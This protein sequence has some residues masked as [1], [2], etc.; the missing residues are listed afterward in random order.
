MEY[1]N[2]SYGSVTYGG[3]LL[4]P[5]NP[6]EQMPISVRD[7]YNQVCDCILESG[8]LTGETLSSD[9]FL[10]FLND[11]LRDVL[12]ASNC[13]IK[14]QNLVTSNGTRVYT[15]PYYV[16]QTVGMLCDDASLFRSSG[17]YWDNSDYYWQAK[18]SSTPG[19]WRD[20]ELPED[21]VEVRPAPSWYGYTVDYGSG[22][23]GTF[24]A[25]SNINTFQVAYAASMYG[26]MQDGVAGDVYT[27]FTAPMYGTIATIYDS[28]L[29]LTEFDTYTQESE[30]SS[31]DAFIQDLPVSFG[32]YVKFGILARVHQMDG[33]LKNMAL[34]KYYKSRL[35]E[36]FRL[37][38]S[39]TGEALMEVVE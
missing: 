11:S 29:N 25:C 21:S 1:G 17:S 10:V 33:E 32:P 26:T 9:E 14:L 13:F 8:G 20:D 7:I 3:E 23:Y 28:S 27:E 34:C 38:R 6:Q 5:A 22:F 36:L 18:P 12:E 16:N 15:H 37:L 19:E 31:L 30:I 2:Y 24:S 35:M 4:E 39:V